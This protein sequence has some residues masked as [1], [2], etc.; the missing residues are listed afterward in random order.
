M[1]KFP[2]E[3]KRELTTL[4]SEIWVAADLYW[5]GKHQDS[6]KRDVSRLWQ[7][8]AATGPNSWSM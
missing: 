5:G 6:S 7:S 3:A 2:L 8:A 1:V 4:H